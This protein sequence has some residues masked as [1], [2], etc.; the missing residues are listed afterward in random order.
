VKCLA[1]ATLR[2]LN[3][4]ARPP[5]PVGRAP[6]IRSSLGWTGAQL[7]SH[8]LPFRTSYDHE[9][10]RVSKSSFKAIGK[11]INKTINKT[12]IK[13]IQGLSKKAGDRQ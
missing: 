12:I 4:R 2:K 6:F 5:E 3:A 8:H 1:R 7:E 11:T 10:S 9:A 13:A